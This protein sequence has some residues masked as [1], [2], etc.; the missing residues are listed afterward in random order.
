[1]KHHTYFNNG[2]QQGIPFLLSGHCSHIPQNADKPLSPLPIPISAPVLPW[3][4][5]C[6]HHQQYI[7]VWWCSSFNIANSNFHVVII[8]VTITVFFIIFST[9]KGLT[10]IETHRSL[11][12]HKIEKFPWTVILMLWILYEEGLLQRITWYKDNVFYCTPKLYEVAHG[13]KKNHVDVTSLQHR[14][15][16]VKKL[17]CPLK[18]WP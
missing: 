18:E 14:Q 11:P 7:H 2:F 12:T 4:K 10:I 16:P 9:W 5:P 15:M 1:M 8:A 3:I 17:L 6:H 13:D